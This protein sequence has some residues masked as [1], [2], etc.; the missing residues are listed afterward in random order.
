MW[1]LKFIYHEVEIRSLPWSANLERNSLTVRLRPDEKRDA[2]EPLD[3]GGGHMPRALVVPLPVRVQR[4]QLHA[5]PGVR[6]SEGQP[7]DTCSASASSGR[8]ARSKGS[9]FTSRR[10]GTEVASGAVRARG[11]PRQTYRRS[12]S[13]PPPS[14][15]TWRP[16]GFAPSSNL[17]QFKTSTAKLCFSSPSLLIIDYLLCG[18]V[19]YIGKYSLR[20]IC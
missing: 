13:P 2:L 3:V 8:I 20:G 14:A 5:P 18:K 1:T 19:E 9:S 16:S 4:V 7:T 17:A 15:P 11:R 6:H 10:A 12:P